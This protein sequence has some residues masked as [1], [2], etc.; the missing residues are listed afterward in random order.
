M[1]INLQTVR[2]LRAGRLVLDDISLAVKPGEIVGLLGEN[3]AG[4]STL[5]DAIAGEIPVTAGQITLAGR[6]LTELDI[7]EQSRRRAVLPQ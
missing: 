1:T 5:I 7:T 6:H 4:K 2:L 3:G